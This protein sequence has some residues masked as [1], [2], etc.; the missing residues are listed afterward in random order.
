MEAEGSNDR[1]LGLAL[2]YQALGRSKE[3][4][5]ALARETGARGNVNP[6]GIAVGHAYRGEIDQAFE[7]LEKAIA[8]RDL[9]LG[10]SSRI[11]RCSHRPC[12]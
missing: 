10:H 11:S 6:S 8:A 4:D 9:S 7:W 1:D 5:A 12:R 2:V 3:S